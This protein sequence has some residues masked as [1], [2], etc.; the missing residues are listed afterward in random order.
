ME[1]ES[2]S[3]VGNNDVKTKRERIKQ[4][5]KELGV[6]DDSVRPEKS[7]LSKYGKYFVAVVLFALL[8]AYGLEYSKQ[9]EMVDVQV[10]ENNTVSN[11]VYNPAQHSYPGYAYSQYNRMVAPNY[12]PAPPPPWM[13]PLAVQQENTD[14]EISKN[15]E[16]NKNNMQQYNY[17]YYARRYSA[18]PRPY[19]NNYSRYYPITPQPMPAYGYR[20]VPGAYPQTYPGSYPG[21]YRA[22]TPPVYAAPYGRQPY[23][24]GWQR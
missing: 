14:K 7:L 9:D 23:Y 2:Q 3:S 16:L 19:R 21:S 20:Q 8:V 12:R 4:R 18:Y 1:S 17:P 24:N 22:P 15:S 5:L 11:P 6:S 10:A 13:R